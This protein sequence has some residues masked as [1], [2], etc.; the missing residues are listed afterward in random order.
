MNLLIFIILACT[1]AAKAET[2]L[3]IKE[4]FKQLSSENQELRVSK[5]N[6][7]FKEQNLQG[8]KSRVWPS[9]SLSAAANKGDGAS[10][11]SADLGTGVSTP[12]DS[13][14]S[15]GTQ[16]NNLSD[17]SA[18][19]TSQTSLGYFLFTGF[20]IDEDIKNSQRSILQV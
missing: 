18:G 6:T 2:P 19:W 9:L 14:G 13:L 8:S 1:T 20:S 16:A 17:V 10:S 4:L 12:G 3:Q 5:L 15:S 7:M 11:S